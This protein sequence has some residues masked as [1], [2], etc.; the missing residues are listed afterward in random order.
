MAGTMTEA[1][2][3][4]NTKSRNDNRLPPFLPVVRHQTNTGAVSRPHPH[5]TDL[6]RRPILRNPD[7]FVARDG[8]PRLGGVVCSPDAQFGFAGA[9]DARIH[10]W[11]VA[12]GDRTRILE[13][14]RGDG[15]NRFR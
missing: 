4:A 13:A 11:T 2:A 9:Q 10:Q 14:A 1:P 6:A 5:S 3:Q 8:G 15:L 7:Q 12:T